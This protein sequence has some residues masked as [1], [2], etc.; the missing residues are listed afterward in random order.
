MKTKKNGENVKIIMTKEEYRRLVILVRT[1]I[2]R[3]I[4]TDKITNEEKEEFL[5][6]SSQI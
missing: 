1:G 2:I 4:L 3:K 6:I 5:K